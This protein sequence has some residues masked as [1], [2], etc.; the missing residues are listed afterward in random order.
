MGKPS[1]D[2]GARGERE[3]ATLFRAHGFPVNRTPNSG[4]LAILGDLTGAVGLHVE[5]K[6]AETLRV[7]DWI[8]QAHEEAG[9]GETPVVVFRTN[10]GPGAEVLGSWHAIL[11]L[12][13]LLELLQTVETFAEAP[14]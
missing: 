11:P 9:D 14:A 12:D 3:V 1:R 13:A 7:P 8:R 10:G 2:K 5:V 6:R 4:G